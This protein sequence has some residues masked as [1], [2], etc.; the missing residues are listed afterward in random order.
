MD[1]KSKLIA[2]LKDV[3]RRWEEQLLIMNEAEIVTRQLS[4]G[5][6]VKDDVA[7]L[8]AWLQVSIARLEAALSGKD[9]SYPDWVHGLDPDSDSEEDTQAF[10]E[11]IYL[12]H[13]EDSWPIVYHNWQE[14]FVHF[15]ELA[16]KIPEEVLSDKDRYPWLKGYPLLAIL[17]GALEHHEEHMDGFR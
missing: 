14:G 6:S 16:E 2:Q 11:G 10:N 15:I 9:P 8:R 4:P 17:Q 1:N 13:C 3:L 12:T 7:H 5:R